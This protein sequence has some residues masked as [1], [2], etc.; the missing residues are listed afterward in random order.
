MLRGA[1]H[2]FP[3]RGLDG[4]A[5]VRVQRRPPG[6]VIAFDLVGLVATQREVAIVAIDLAGSYV[7]VPYPVTGGVEGEAVALLGALAVGDISQGAGGAQRPSIGGSLP[8]TAAI[9]HPDP[10]VRLG[11]ITI[12]ARKTPA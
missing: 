9:H 3:E 4:I 6:F 5:L 10:C 2:V 1:A 11:T 8:H 12:L 7:P